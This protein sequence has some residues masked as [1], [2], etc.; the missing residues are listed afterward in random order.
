MS[1]KIWVTIKDILNM[2]RRLITSD[3]RSDITAAINLIFAFSNFLT[4]E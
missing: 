1:L 2:I 4:K 3:E